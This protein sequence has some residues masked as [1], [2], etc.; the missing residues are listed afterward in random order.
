[1]SGASIIIPTYNNARFVVQAVE[2]ALAQTYP[3]FEVIVVDDGSTDET[4]EA[5]AAYHQQIRYLYQENRGPSAARNAG[6]RASQ[7][8][9]V[10]FLDSDDL[11][12]PDKLER[13]T[14]FLDAYPEFCLVYSAWQQIGEEGTQTLGEV[15]PQRQGRLL[16]ELLRRA[17]FFFLS[18]ALIR[19]SC[20]ERVGL[21]DE[22][23]R[24][25]EDAD[26]WLRLARAGCAFGYIDRPLLQRRVHPRSLTAEV[27]AHQVQAWLASL[28][29]FYA[30]PELPD[31]IQALEGEAYS[32]LHYETAARYYR[33][34][35][36]ALGQDQ[37]RQAM[38]RCPSMPD[39]WLL[40]WL[41]GSALDPRT[42]DPRRL[43]D[44]IFDHLPPEASALRSLRRRA[45]GRY[46]TAAAFMEYHNQ[47]LRG[48]RQ[49]ILPAV[50]GDPSILRNR[51]FLSVAARSLLG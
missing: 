4:R 9:F 25:S 29:R 31:D 36:I 12:S 14:A 7:G 10:L 34:G 19:R 15:R 37:L 35:Q 2:S 22:A 1:M 18:A 43:L 24:W 46:H 41:A 30:D 23:M 8:D 13:Q 16:K 42:G 50:I 51:G 5:L 20:L 6:F 32:I 27:N 3:D 40:D 48:I 11:I 38:R 28:D 49:H 47:H 33:A 26:L 21:F 39:E 44:M 17:F 45:Y